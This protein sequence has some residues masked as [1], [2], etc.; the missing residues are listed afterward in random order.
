MNNT[1]NF[2]RQREIYLCRA[3]RQSGDTK[4]RP[5]VVVSLDIRNEYSSTVLVVP[6]S[7]NTQ[8]AVDNPS[9]VLIQAGEGGLELTSVAM[10][11]VITNVEKRYLERGP[12]GQISS[13]SLEQIQR[14][15]QAAIGVF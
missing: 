4:K 3:L 10:C 8:S 11:E 1:G 13:E 9:R 5:V 2:P 14:A 15:I 12:Y 6:F 7:S